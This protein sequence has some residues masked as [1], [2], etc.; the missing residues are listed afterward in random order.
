MGR[1]TAR[2]LHSVG[3]MTIGDLAET[4]EESL[5]FRLGKMGLILSS[6]AR[7]QDNTPVQKTNHIRNIK[8]VG[9]SSTTP[10]DLVDVQDVH[11]MFIL[12]A[13]SVCS[14]LRELAS[15]CTVVE[16][17]VRDTQLNS[18]TRQKKIDIPT[19]SSLEIANVAL[20]L[21]QANYHWTYPIRSIGVRGS[22][23]VEASP[24]DQLSLFQDETRRQRW[25]LLD[26]AMDKVRN[27]YGYASIQRAT[28]Y[29]DSLLSGIKPKE[30]VVHPIG[31][32]GM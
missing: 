17:S 31:F 6:F 4:S 10:R 18:F 20:E 16:I 14:R 26:S 27:R 2:K 24:F 23:L 1:A 32:F 19:Y 13:E 25:E 21:F 3:I 11:L 7:G 28:I 30:H 8:S 9:N 15:K 29:T 22:G 12:L 5:K